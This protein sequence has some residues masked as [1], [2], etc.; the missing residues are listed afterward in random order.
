[1]FM[2]ESKMLYKGLYGGLGAKDIHA[3][4]GC[5]DYPALQ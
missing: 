2:A 4:K 5:T 1:M 3:R